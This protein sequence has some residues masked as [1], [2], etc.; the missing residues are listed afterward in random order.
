MELQ[1][2]KPGNHRTVWGQNPRQALL[3]AVE[4]GP[5]R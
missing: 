2:V 5:Q 3:L 4:G 1:V